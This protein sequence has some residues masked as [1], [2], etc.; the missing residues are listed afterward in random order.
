MQLV[1]AVIQPRRLETVKEALKDA[2]V[3]GMT[4]TEARGFAARVATPRPT[5]VPNPRWNSFPR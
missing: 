5:G 2:G 3:A 4:V 1:T